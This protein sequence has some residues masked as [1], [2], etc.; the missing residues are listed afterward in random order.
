MSYHTWINGEEIFGNN[1]YYDEWIDFIKSKGIEVDEDGCYEGE[2]N[3]VQGIFE[4]VDKITRRLI[5]ERHKEV[6]KGE[7]KI[8]AGRLYP[9]DIVHKYTGGG[10][11]GNSPSPAPDPRWARR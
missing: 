7:K 1:E 3:D 11:R 2:I 9:H 8:N 4:T 10:W 6:E 5:D